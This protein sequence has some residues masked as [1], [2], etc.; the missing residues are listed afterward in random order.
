MLIE[1]QVKNFRSFRDLVTLNMVKTSGKELLDTHTFAPN[2]PATPDLLRSSAVYGPNASGKTNLVYAFAAMAGLIRNSARA[3]QKGDSLPVTPFLMDVGSRKK[4]CEFQAIFVSEGVRYQYGFSATEKRIVKEWLQAYP[5]KMP[6]RLIEREYDARNKSY[7]WGSMTKFPGSRKL[8][9]DATR[10]N[11]LFLSTAI[12]LNNEFLQPVFNW[13]SKTLRTVSSRGPN[14]IYSME[15]CNNPDGKKAVLDFLKAID[16]NIDDISVK[17][18]RIDLKA[19]PDDMPDELKKQL[20]KLPFMHLYSS[21]RLSNDKMQVFDWDEESDGTRRLFEFAG[22]MLETLK[23]GHVVVIDELDRH[24]H[25]ALVGFL[26]QLFHDP[27]INSRNAQLVLTTHA[28]ATLNHELFR[29]DQIW[30]CEKDKKRATELFPLS[31]LSPRKK[32]NF[33]YGYLSGRYGAFPYIKDTR[34]IKQAISGL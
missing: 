8:L 27:N 32:E 20:Q 34:L 7:T 11:A 30:F 6:Q 1:F 33:E 3:G 31:A 25:P 16:I 13:F 18:E 23:N 4:P 17:E 12:Q 19:F 26:I 22:P 9:Q 24:L 29:R 21:H 28:T 15:L 10:P 2:A 14:S 5:N